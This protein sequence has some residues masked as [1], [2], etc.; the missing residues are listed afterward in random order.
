M[1]TVLNRMNASTT[2][3]PLGALTREEWQTRYASRV[4]ER[5]GWSRPGAN[6]VAKAAA[7]LQ[8]GQEGGFDWDAPEDAADEVMSSSESN[9]G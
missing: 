4:M 2:P 7:T 1:S 9:R 8:A 6:A 5:A 3:E